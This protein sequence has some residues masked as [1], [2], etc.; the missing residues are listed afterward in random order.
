MSNPV[1]RRA[2]VECPARVEIFDTHDPALLG[3]GA[4][5]PQRFCAAVHLPD[6]FGHLT[7]EPVIKE[8]GATAREAFA[9]L[10]AICASQGIRIMLEAETNEGR[11]ER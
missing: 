1:V 6:G 9:V 2:R 3:L 7:Q 4:G 8:F 10:E 5:L 11:E